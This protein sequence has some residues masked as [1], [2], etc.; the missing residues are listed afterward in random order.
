MW[1]GRFSEKLTQY[2]SIFYN[3]QFRQLTID[4]DYCL[5]RNKSQ[6]PTTFDLEKKVG[7][8]E[9]LDPRGGIFW[10]CVNKVGVLGFL[11]KVGKNAILSFKKFY[12]IAI[13]FKKFKRIHKFSKSSQLLTPQPI[14]TKNFRETV[15]K[16]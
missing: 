2:Q 6:I 16:T 9:R 14:P 3:H 4:V 10:T 13:F 11:E 8:G 1:K 12:K 7:F 5:N 15:Q